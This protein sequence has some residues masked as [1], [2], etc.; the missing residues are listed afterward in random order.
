MG[1]SRVALPCTG[2][3]IRRSTY[4]SYSPR[5]V[6]PET[7]ALG[8][9]A[10]VAVGASHL[11]LRHLRLYVPE[12]IAPRHGS[13]I[14]FFLPSHMVEVKHHRVCLPAIYARMSGKVSEYPFTNFAHLLNLQQRNSFLLFVGVRLVILAIV[15]RVT[16]LALRTTT[17]LLCW[18]YR[19]GAQLFSLSAL[20]AFLH[21]RKPTHQYL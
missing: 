21:G 18:V 2:L 3:K 16:L 10:S 7:I 4:L 17:V 15:I 14:L 19:E 6:A 13:H 20:V 9:N 12:R 11:A 5:R 8:C 1:L